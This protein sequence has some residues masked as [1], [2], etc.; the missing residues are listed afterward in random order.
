MLPRA[1]TYWR[2]GDPTLN[3]T[4]QSSPQALTRPGALALYNRDEGGG[5]QGGYIGFKIPLMVLVKINLTYAMYACFLSSP[6]TTSYP[7]GAIK[8]PQK[9]LPKFPAHSA[10]CQRSHISFNYCILF[11]II[12]M[13]YY[14]FVSL[15]IVGALSAQGPS[16]QPRYPQCTHTRLCLNLFC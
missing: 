7:C 12:L 3:V 10:L 9:I 13:F 1:S 4:N 14:L 8:C 15:V 6:P 16:R 2:Q 11:H 5:G